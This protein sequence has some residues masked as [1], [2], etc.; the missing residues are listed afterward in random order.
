LAPTRRAQLIKDIIVAIQDEQTQNAFLSNAIASRLGVTSTELEVLGTLVAR[1]P[2]SAGDLARRTGLTSGAVTRL[3]DRLVERGSVR[4][5][6][7]PQDRRRVLVEITPAAMRACDPYY[8]PI[9]NEGTALLDERTEKDLEV[10]L[11][12]LRIN[13]EFT[14]RHTERVEAMPERVQLPRRRV[15]IKGRVFGQT[16]RIKI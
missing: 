9:A 2:L 7:D 6:A 13:Y 5:L 11:E 1:G 10:I 16:V 8:A 3:I 12:Y 14:K 4:R 15:N